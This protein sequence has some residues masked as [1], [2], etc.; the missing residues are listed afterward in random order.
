[1]TNIRVHH[2]KNYTCIHND[3]IRDKRLSWKARGIHHFLLS[4]PDNWTVNTKYLV[5][6]SGEGRT[7]V[8]AALK[9]LE[10]HG[11]L[12]RKQ[13][14]N[15][16]GQFSGWE[17]VLTE[18]PT[19]SG[20]PDHGEETAVR[21]SA[22]GLSAN[23]LSV[24]GKPDCLISNKKTTSNELLTSIDPEEVISPASQENEIEVEILD[25]EPVHKCESPTGDFTQ[26]DSGE[27]L[28]TDRGQFSAAEPENLKVLQ[29]TQAI[30]HDW[31]K[32]PWKLN[33]VEFKP[34]VKTSV[35]M[36]NPNHY[37]LPNGTPN[38]RF[39][40][41]RLKKLD[42]DL[43]RIDV[44]A[45]EAYVTLTDYWKTA[46]ALI[47][48]ET[49]VNAEQYKSAAKQVSKQLELESKKQRIGNAIAHL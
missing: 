45:I 42:D 5:S 32:R 4:H 36:S 48:P 18:L 27:Q 41:S 22:N 25:P 30:A 17:S 3:A 29:E 14:Q 44:A 46:S 6:Q 37:S 28:N 47:N 34:E 33:A 40:Q 13:I 39:I 1:M 43:K 10:D 26:F 11:Y 20:K 49:G 35:W 21:F 2:E 8:L 19:V 23:G 7:A 31:R 12:S 24:N 15:E 38:Y 9:E 16:S